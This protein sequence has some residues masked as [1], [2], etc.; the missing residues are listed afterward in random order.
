MKARKLFTICCAL[1]AL[2]AAALSS[3]AQNR[4]IDETPL[5]PRSVRQQDD[6]PQGVRDMLIR[7]QIEKTKK[8]FD[9]RLERADRA[10]QLSRQIESSVEKT[11]IL[12]NEDRL[13]LDDLEKLTKDVLDE[14][15]G[16]AGDLLK[17]ESKQVPAATPAVAAKE[18]DKAVAVMVAELK[19]TT[20][21]TI[22][23]AAIESSGAV[24]RIVR[25]LKSYR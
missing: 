25:V 19:K 11:S 4:Q 2:F 6:P 17:E 8:D 16:D 5:A 12:S 1:A 13:R 23:A 7:R 3:S 22:S 14:I 15:G 24:L 21:F 9:E 10:A 20:R 18:L